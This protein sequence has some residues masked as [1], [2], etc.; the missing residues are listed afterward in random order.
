M[1][2]SPIAILWHWAKNRFQSLNLDS[3]AGGTR[4]V[5]GWLQAVA[6][7]DRSIMP[8]LTEQKLFFT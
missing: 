4:M 5:S 7:A 6:E 8:L 3:S 1:I 2:Y